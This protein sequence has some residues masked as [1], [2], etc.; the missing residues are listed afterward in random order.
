MRRL[1][2]LFL[3]FATSVAWGGEVVES[4]IEHNGNRYTI[5]LVMQLNVDAA[6][7]YDTPVGMAAGGN[8]LYVTQMLAGKVAVLQPQAPPPPPPAAEEEAAE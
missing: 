3:V 7:V 4:H 1:T 5:H 2:Y 6:T 8:S